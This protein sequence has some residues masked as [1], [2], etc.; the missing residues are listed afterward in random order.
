M[1]VNEIG[2][3]NKPVIELVDHINI[4]LANYQIHY[5]KVRG[6][7][8]NV[9]G[10]NFFDLHIKFEELYNNAQT[11]I[12]ELAE[13]V[14]TLGKSP[15]STYADYIKVSEI[16]E[17]KTDGLSADKMVTAILGDFQKLIEMERE[18]IENATENAG[19]EGTADMIIGFLK[20]KEK[21]SW[22]FRAWEGK[23]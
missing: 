10:H 6:C 20:F 19:D 1:T 11:T 4:L 18:V 8:W 5:Q 12:D 15:F 13:R 22:M 21:T 2:L 17:I 14:L 7:H 9:K 16:K 23:N 3:K